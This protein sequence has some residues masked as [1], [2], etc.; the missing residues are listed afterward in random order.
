MQKK[1]N[2][3]KKEKEKKRKSKT[4]SLFF[5]FVLDQHA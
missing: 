3:P 4:K 5:H 2:K 1:A